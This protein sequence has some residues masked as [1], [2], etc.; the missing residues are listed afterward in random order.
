MR[1]RSCHDVNS[2]T[3]H[4]QQATGAARICD[5]IASAFYYLRRVDLADKIHHFGLHKESDCSSHME[6][7]NRLFREL[8]KDDKDFTR[9]VQEV[10]IKEEEEYDIFQK[11][12]YK[13]VFVLSLMDSNGNRNHF[14]AYC[15]GLI[16]HPSQRLALLLT[17]ENLDMCCGENVSFSRTLYGRWYRPHPHVTKRKRRRKR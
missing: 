17:R 10:R 3:V 5:A 14:V 2:H 1:V 15:D 7:Y 6:I 13:G 12:N 8:L 4:Y 11:Q 9:T 16:F